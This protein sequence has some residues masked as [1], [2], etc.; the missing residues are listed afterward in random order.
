[1][2]KDII[3]SLDYSFFAEAAL[4]LFV[5]TFFIIFYGTARLSREAADRFASIPLRDSIEDPR[6]E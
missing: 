2:I 1:M 3:C 5:G 6:H 4:A